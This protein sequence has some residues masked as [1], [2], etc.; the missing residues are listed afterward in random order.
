MKRIVD[1]GARGGYRVW[2]KYND[3]TEGEV[4]LSDLAGRGVFKVWEDR[5]VF[6]TVRVTEGGALMWEGGLDLCPDA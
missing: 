2:L 1:A 4:N 6:E 5:R 3:G